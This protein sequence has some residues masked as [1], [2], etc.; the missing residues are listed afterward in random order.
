M[1]CQTPF[2]RNAKMPSVPYADYTA[3]GVRF[4]A[5]FGLAGWGIKII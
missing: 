5:P 4:V 1:E 2:Y 3:T